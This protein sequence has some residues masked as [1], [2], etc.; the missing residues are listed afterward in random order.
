MC[1]SMLEVPLARPLGPTQ[2]PLAKHDRDRPVLL[3]DRCVHWV[4][5]EGVELVVC[6]EV[7]APVALVWRFLSPSIC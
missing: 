1:G 6:L 7:G 4:Q 3:A 2:E 5:T